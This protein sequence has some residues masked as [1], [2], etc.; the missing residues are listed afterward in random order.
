[1][2]LLVDQTPAKKWDKTVT[3][4]ESSYKRAIKVALRKQE[5]FCLEPNFEAAFP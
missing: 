5:N 2:S 4:K 3:I 1:M